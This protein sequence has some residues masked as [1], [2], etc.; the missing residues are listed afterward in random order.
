M[1]CVALAPIFLARIVE[2]SHNIAKL[3]ETIFA[4]PELGVRVSLGRAIIG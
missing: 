3:P 4:T 1:L 2:N